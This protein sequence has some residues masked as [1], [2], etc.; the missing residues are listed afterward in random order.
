MHVVCIWPYMYVYPRVYTTHTSIWLHIYV[1]ACIYNKRT[2]LTYCAF[3][4][5]VV[6]NQSDSCPGRVCV[7][8]SRVNELRTCM[9]VYIYIYM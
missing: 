6:R 9:Y 8:Y 5:I 2:Y 7:L 3:T 4:V 1:Y